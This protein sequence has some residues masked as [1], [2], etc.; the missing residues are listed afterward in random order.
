[1][2]IYTEFCSENNIDQ[3]L[4]SSYI[5]YGFYVQGYARALMDRAV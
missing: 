4:Q 3:E 1:M 5:A 2:L